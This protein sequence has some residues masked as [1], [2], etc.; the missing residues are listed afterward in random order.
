MGERAGWVAG[1]GRDTGYQ[2]PERRQSRGCTPAPATAAGT[3]CDVLALLLCVAVGLSL[4]RLLGSGQPVLAWRTGLGAV[5]AVVATVSGVLSLARHRLSGDARLAYLGTALVGYGAVALPLGAVALQP[6]VDVVEIGAWR[7]GAAV[8]VLVL[9]ARGLAS[10][11]VD[12]RLSVVRL[13]AGATAVGALISVALL[14]GTTVL[15]TDM[16]D[17]ATRALELG[18]LLLAVGYVGTGLGQGRRVL[19][20]AGCGLLLV[21][22]ALALQLIDPAPSSF[23]ALSIA[24]LRLVGVSFVLFALAQDLVVA[25]RGRLLADH[26]MRGRWVVA[27]AAAHHARRQQEERDHEIRNAL[28]GIAGASRA[29]EASDGRPDLAHRTELRRAV[30]VELDRVQSMVRD[31]RPSG[32]PLRYDVAPVLAP[33]VAARRSLGERV[34]LVCAGDT[35][36]VGRPEA[37]AQVVVNLLTN[38]ARHAEGAAVTV[39]AECVADKVVVSVLDDGSAQGSARPGR[40]LGLVVSRRLAEEE[41]GRLQVVRGEQGGFGVSLELP[42]ALRPV[43]SDLVLSAR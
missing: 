36:T 16:L 13:A 8:A 22:V 33:L 18:W 7:V 37:L 20:R 11:P 2:G 12:S 34:E 21:A 32:T 35:T 3:V 5:G 28:A 39:R 26:D 14:A 23:P 19:F 9:A 27:E 17:L 4:T 43:C 10:P 30:R 1:R 24:T 41:G 15:D 29:L 6:G 25:F 38:C 40:G 31:D 42:A